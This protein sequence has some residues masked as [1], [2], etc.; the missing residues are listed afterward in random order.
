M[1]GRYLGY[2]VSR[3]SVGREV[4]W[5]RSCRVLYNSI[6]RIFRICLTRAESGCKST[7]LS[8]RNSKTDIIISFRGGS[9]MKINAGF[10]LRSDTILRMVTEQ[11]NSILIERSLCNIRVNKCFLRYSGSTIAN[12][13]P[14]Y[15]GKRLGI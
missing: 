11:T 5:S 3:I 2:F 6:K 1:L 9:L 14:I 10:S 12:E 13:I 4:G 15:R 8:C 7:F